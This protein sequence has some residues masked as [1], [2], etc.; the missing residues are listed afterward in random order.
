MYI[1]VALSVGFSDEIA[2]KVY[3]LVALSVAFS[4]EIT[5]KVY[6]LVAR[7]SRSVMK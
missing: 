3:I 5:S 1:L 6:I 2:S 4:D 7:R